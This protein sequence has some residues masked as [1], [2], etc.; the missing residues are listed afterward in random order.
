MTPTARVT[1]RGAD[2]VRG[3]HPW[4]Y[5]SDLVETD[6][7]GGD[8]VR[9]VDVRDR[10]L[11]YALY[12]DRSEIA[13][14]MVTLG[15]RPA[16]LSLWRARLEQACAY[17]RSLRIDATAYRLVHAEADRL[18]SFVVDRYDQYLVV[19]TL[20]QGTDRMLPELVRLLVEVT[21]PK[22]VLARNDPRV[23]RLEGL[24]PRVELLY[25][26]VPSPVVIREGDVEFEV[27]LWKGQKTGAFLDQRENRDA[28]AAYAH[29]RLLDAFS[30]QGAFAVR[31]A[32]RCREVIALD[33]SEDAVAQIGRNA[34]RNGLRHV[35]G[36]VANVFDA[37]REFERAGE[38]FDTIVLDPP[39]FAKNKAAVPKALAGY[40][41]IN[42]RAMKLLAPGGV[43]VTCSCSYNVDDATFGAVVVEAAADAR[44]SL[45]L[46]EKRLQ[47]RDHPIL[48]GFPE[49]ADLKC[50]ILRKLEP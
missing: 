34:T 39:A 27:D 2:R 48:V 12:S 50:L 20:S 31:L 26:E 18:P 42:L 35:A 8:T 5:R 23:R 49:S 46:V 10:T 45:V 40:K 44:A 25:G 36:R 33:S 7:R 43:L 14:R 38:R 21:Q 22:G 17:R 41:E 32:R 6:A 4:I 28:A 9:V 16:D 11:G 3:G 19:Q 30:Y 47:S 1:R 24:E 37:L 13:L 15:D 29:G